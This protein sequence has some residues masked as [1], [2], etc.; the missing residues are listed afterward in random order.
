MTS[1]SATGS[2]PSP[3]APNHSANWSVKIP[4]ADPQWSAA[5]VK[6]DRRKYYTTCPSLRK[7]KRTKP[8][9]SVLVVLDVGDSL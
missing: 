9:A 1:P 4:S 8:A 5:T 2:A 7:P 3:N 6:R